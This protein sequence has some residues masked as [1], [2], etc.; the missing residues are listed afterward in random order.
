[1][2]VNINKIFKSLGE[3]HIKPRIECK[4][5]FSMSVQA[6]ATHYCEPR[7]AYKDE[8]Y[9]SFEVGFPSEKEEL[10]ME[11]AEKPEDPTGSV[12]GY[13]PAS[14]LEEIIVKHGGIK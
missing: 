12:Y 4:D 14:V 5:G 11:Y 6:S 1:M 13:V 9:W 2:T 7:T 10:L 3:D 8:S